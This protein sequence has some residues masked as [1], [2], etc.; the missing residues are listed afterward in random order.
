V[1]GSSQ[2]KPVSVSYSVLYGFGG[3]IAPRPGTTISKSARTFNVHFRLTTA[4]GKPLATRVAAALAVRHVVRV[5]LSGPRIRTV[6]VECR[7]VASRG[8]FECSVAIP[9]GVRTGRHR[10]TLSAMERF[11]QVSNLAPAVGKAANPEKLRFR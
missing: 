9:A 5:Q 10:Y 3:F 11:G 6:T 1:A 2:L 8:Y 4:A 7:W